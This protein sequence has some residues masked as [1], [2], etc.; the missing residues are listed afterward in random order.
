MCNFH[1]IVKEYI[2]E[3]NKDLLVINDLDSLDN[4]DD[5]I[6]DD[7]INTINSFIYE[8]NNKNI[9][10][11]NQNDRHYKHYEKMFLLIFPGIFLILLLY[12]FYL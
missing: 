6:I 12:I 8:I 2:G 5:K 7:L 3:N 10:F 9:D 1:G 11:I 4:E